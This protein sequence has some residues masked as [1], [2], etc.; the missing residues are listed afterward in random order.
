MNTQE[1]EELWITLNELYNANRFLEYIE[2][3]S[4]AIESAIKLGM[5]D[6][7]ILLLNYSCA[8]YFQTGDLQ[9]SINVLEQYRELTF[10]YGSEIDVI[11]YY[12]IASI[13]W[14]TFGHLKKSE[15]LMLKGLKIAE[16]IQHVESLGKL[17]NNLSDL[18]ISMGNYQKAK[19]FAFKSLYYANAFDVKHKKPYTGIIHPKTN[20]AV[21]HIELKEFSKANTILK[22]LLATIDQPPYSK[23]QLE[24][25]YAYALLCERQGRVNEAIDLYQKTKHYALQNN[26][27]AMLQMIYNSLVKLIEKQGNKVVLCAIQKEY[28]HILL[29]MQQENYSHVL[30]EME[31][32]D[33]KKQFEKN[34]YMDPLTNIYNRR[35]FDEHAEKMVETAAKSSQPLALIMVDLDHFKEI[36]DTNGHL[37]GDDALT[38]TAKTLKDFFQP[39]PSIVARFG[40]DEFIVLSQVKDGATIQTMAAN[41]YQALSS[42]SLTVQEE[43]V[44]LAFS[45]GVST[46]NN[47]KIVQVEELIRYA[48]EALYT[49]K[50]NGRNQITHYNHDCNMGNG[51]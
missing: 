20:L 36:N 10:Q 34:A 43:V 50:R 41:L 4:A 8:S 11:Q 39:V 5:Y 17:Y 3:S 15:E 51:I 1:F 48:D 27:L 9:L 16:N 30:F 42:L 47:G 23:V 12:N 6:K 46:N 38:I 28:I 45:I 22:E 19:E 14:G 32:K 29:E 40:G 7:A 33:H 49:S 25:F 35:Y 44:Q 24:V 31:Y 21:A 13:Y 2:I 26:D 18:E 37:F